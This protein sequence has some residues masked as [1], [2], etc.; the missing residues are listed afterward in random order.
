MLSQK[1]QTITFEIGGLLLQ[2]GQGL[3]VLGN[4]FLGAINGSLLLLGEGGEFLLP[5]LELSSTPLV[6]VQFR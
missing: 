1:R 2:L 6:L 4:V 3:L 5:L